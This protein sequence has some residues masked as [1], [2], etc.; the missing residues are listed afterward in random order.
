MAGEDTRGAA[1][2]S[3]EVEED[4]EDDIRVRDR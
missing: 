1:D 4:E 2:G 3:E